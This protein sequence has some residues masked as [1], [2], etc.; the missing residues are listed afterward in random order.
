MKGMINKKW[1]LPFFLGILHPHISSFL[2]NQRYKILETSSVSFY[3]DYLICLKI[4][5]ANMYYIYYTYFI[6]ICRLL[7][8]W[9]FGEHLTVPRI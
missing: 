6:Y 2:H 7:P 4:L 5:T 8:K 9:E 1:I 3:N